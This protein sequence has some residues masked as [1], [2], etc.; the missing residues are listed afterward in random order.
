MLL[1]C[2]V[3]LV[4]SFMYS[5]WRRSSTRR[6]GSTRFEEE[7]K[8]NESDVKLLS[9]ARTCLAA[10]MLQYLCMKASTSARVRGRVV[11]S[12]G[13]FRSREEAP[14]S[15]WLPRYRQSVRQSLGGVQGYIGSSLD[16]SCHSG[17]GAVPHFDSTCRRP[18]LRPIGER[19]TVP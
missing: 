18:E 14:R 10:K 1:T 7:L 6:P 11:G 9:W 3:T 19:N 15:P 12:E 16:V 2:T 8:I 4:E 17:K 5:R 13:I